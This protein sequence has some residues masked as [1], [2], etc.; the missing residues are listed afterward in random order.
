MFGKGIFLGPYK[1][2]FDALLS[3]SCDANPPPAVVSGPHIISFDDDSASLWKIAN[4][5]AYVECQY[6]QFLNNYIL[7]YI[8]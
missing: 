7:S 8:F 3:P 6:L 1:A 2:Y 5:L 4:A